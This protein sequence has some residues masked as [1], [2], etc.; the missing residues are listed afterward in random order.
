MAREQYTNGNGV[1]C[2]DLW[3]R[4]MDSEGLA[5][6]AFGYLL[7]LLCEDHLEH[8]QVAAVETKVDIKVPSAHAGL[9]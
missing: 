4:D 3:G 8:H 2:V 7:Q 1:G 9:T 5:W 6:E